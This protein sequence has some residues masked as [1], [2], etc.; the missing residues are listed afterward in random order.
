MQNTPYALTK[1]AKEQNVDVKTLI[2]NALEQADND[3]YKA[4]DD[5][6]V[7]RQG[8]LYQMKEKKLKLYP[9]IVDEDE[10]KNAN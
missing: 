3:V 7:S 8:L 4:A 10:Q 6:G 2:K 5:L 1:K 9:C